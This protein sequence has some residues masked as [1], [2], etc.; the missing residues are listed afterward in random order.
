[1]SMTDF[2]ISLRNDL[3]TIFRSFSRSI[4]WAIEG[5]NEA[6]YHGSSGEGKAQIWIYE[7]E[8]ECRFGEFHRI[9]ERADFESLEQLRA[10]FLDTVRQKLAGDDDA[11]SK[12]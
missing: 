7:D 6:F 12:V 1:M 9:C 8:A 10:Y 4:A 5:K 3:D 11:V 2:Q